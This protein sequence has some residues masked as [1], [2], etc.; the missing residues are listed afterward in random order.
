MYPNLLKFSIAVF[1][2]KT[3]IDTIKSDEGFLYCELGTNMEILNAERFCDHSTSVIENIMPKERKYEQ[4]MRNQEAITKDELI[5]NKYKYDHHM[6]IF[7]TFGAFVFSKREV[8]LEGYGIECSMKIKKYKF[9]TGFFFGKSSEHSIELKKMSK[10]ECYSMFYEK[11]CGNK[12]IECSSAKECSYSELIVEDYPG[13]IGQKEKDFIEC[14]YKKRYLSTLGKKEKVIS[15]GESECLAEN[16]E[17]HLENSIV[18]WSKD[19]FRKCLFENLIKIEFLYVLP[20]SSSEFMVLYSPENKYLFKL[21]GNVTNDCGLIFHHTSQGLFL[22]IDEKS[23]IFNQ[24]IKNIP[25]SNIT[26]QHFQIKDQL[27]LILAEYDYKI[28]LQNAISKQLSCSFLKNYLKI[29][30]KNNRRFERIH[31]PGSLKFLIQKN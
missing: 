18:I 1:V 15:D 7:K 6:P 31:I 12:L 16:E 11:K 9:K 17:C 2:F 30:S 8:F 21:T 28:L 23:S 4:L 10:F 13:W 5:A 19:L 27:D 3:I 22:V 29:I 20:S 14:K 26:I 25:S 24:K